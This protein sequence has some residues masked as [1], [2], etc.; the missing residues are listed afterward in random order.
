[1][2]LGGAETMHADSIKLAIRFL[3]THY[4]RAV[5]APFTG[6]DSAAWRAF[7]ASLEL[8]ALGDGH[9]QT[10][11]VHGM[12]AAVSAMQS[13]T[14]WIAKA[15]IP[16]VLDWSDEDR[17]WTILENLAAARVLGATA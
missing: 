4:G 2:S 13:S 9:G 1:M 8:Y 12:R 7:V 14:Q 16:A 10:C 3:K 17:L 5:F 11:A 6:Q 15:T